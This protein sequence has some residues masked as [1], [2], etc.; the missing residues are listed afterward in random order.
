MSSASSPS[1]PADVL[2]PFLAAA[3]AAARA[4]PDV[5]VDLAREVMA[6]AAS[7]LHDSLALDD[8]DPRDRDVVVQALA[9]DLASEDPGAAVRAR[10]TALAGGDPTLHDPERASG[11][12][13]V[14]L[15]VL[16]L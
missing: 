4:R 3:E 10:E 6:E 15:S 5:E 1:A 11:T 7:M 9:E 8:L 13:L 12:Y 16:Q 14:V 2:D